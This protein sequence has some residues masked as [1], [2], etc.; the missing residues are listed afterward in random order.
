MESISID[1]LSIEQKVGQLFFIG[2]P[3]PEMDRQTV[4]LL[5]LVRPGGVCLFARNIKT[6]E[7]TRELLDSIRTHLAVSPFLSLDQEGG[8]VDRLRRILTPMPAAAKLRT[9]ADAADLG[10]IVGQAISLLGFNMD[11]AP[12]VDVVTPDRA[13]ASNGLNSRAFGKDESDAAEFAE[14]FLSELENAGCLGCIKHFPG[15]G[16]S[17]VD[18]HEDLPLVEIEPDEL[19]TRDLQP[20]RSLLKRFGTRLSVMVA[21]AAYPRWNLQELDQ[22]GKLLPSS[23]SSNVISDLLRNELNFDG[24]VI[25]DDLEMGAIIKNYGIPE[26]CLMALDAG[27]DMLAICADQERIEKGFTAVLNAVKNGRLSE[28]RVNDSLSRI[29]ATKELIKGPVDFNDEKLT[30]LSAEITD[31]NSRLS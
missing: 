3:G 10:R 8:L 31:L 22:N 28:L 13:S 11:F 16:D 14:Q 24:L 27:A 1:D 15:L 5:D 20:Y 9:S 19:L 26:A 25:T 12:V 4:D 2:I 30:S 21:H 29:F 7:Q 18:S 23:L 17:R 6:R